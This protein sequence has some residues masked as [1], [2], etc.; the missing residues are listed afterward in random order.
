M[1]KL[2]S[3]CL[4]FFFSLLS[5]NANETVRLSVGEWAPYTSTD[6]KKGQLAQN[7]VSAAFKVENIDVVYEF[8]GWEKTYQD[9][10]DAKSEGTVPW[11]RT[12]ERL[13]DFYYSKMPI[14]KSKTVFFSL[15]KSSFDWSNYDDLKK[16]KIG[17][18]K[19]FK[20]AKFLIDKG[21]NVSLVET[22][23]QNMKKLLSGEIDITTSS[24]LVGHNLI[25][26]VFSA[27]EAAMFVSH[28][29]EVYPETG[30]HYII[31][32]KHPRGQELMKAF[33]RGFLKLIKSGEFVKI[34]KSS[35][36]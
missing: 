29:K 8:N 36:K 2:M 33:D 14:A 25:K 13:N 19:G 5:V 30:F 23:T 4:L 26:S 10:I 32:K 21:L 17:E 11:S 20:S 34:M 16:Y 3:V 7:I 28:D 12:K 27:Q 24:Y 35:M 31:S 15:K 1:K 22:E 9:A 18:V 6:A